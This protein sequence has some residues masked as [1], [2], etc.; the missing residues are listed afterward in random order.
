MQYL[1][2]GWSQG[3]QVT[4]TRIQ[5][6]WVPQVS[7]GTRVVKRLQDLPSGAPWCPW[8]LGGIDGDE[9]HGEKGR[10]VGEL[11]QGLRRGDAFSTFECG[12]GGKEGP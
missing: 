2:V 5:Q 8:K 1:L 6:S 4:G 10:V 7:Q 3:R 11:G 12:E 9:E